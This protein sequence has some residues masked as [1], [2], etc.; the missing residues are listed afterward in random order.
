MYK[1]IFLCALQFKEA[2]KKKKKD[3]Y[4]YLGKELKNK[5]ENIVVILCKLTVNLHLKDCAA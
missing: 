1:N 3:K 2:K 5:E 4:K